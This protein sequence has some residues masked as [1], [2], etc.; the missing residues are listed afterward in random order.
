MKPW[1]PWALVATA[2]LI[3]AA[4]AIQAGD[5]APCP[6]GQH[7]ASEPRTEWIHEDGELRQAHTVRRVCV[8]E[9]GNVR[10]EAKE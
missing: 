1:L 5:D 8:D 6:E 7:V 10:G 9:S 2:V 4:L 3:V